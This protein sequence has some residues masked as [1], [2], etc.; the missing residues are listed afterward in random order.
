MHRRDFLHPARLLR[1]AGTI[2]GALDEARTLVKA[3]PQTSDDAVLLRFARRAMATIFEVI[4]P[5]GTPHAQHI[6]DD[7]LDLID[8]LEAQLTVYRAESEV[9]QLNQNAAKRAIAVEAELFRLLEL[10]QEL[11]TQTGGAFDIT[12]GALVKAWG[13]Y[14]RAGRVPSSEE[15]RSVR[16]KI[17]MR[18]LQFDTPSQTVRFLR[19]GLEINLASIGKGHALDRAVRLLRSKWKVPSA[20]VHGGHSS[21]F[22]VGSE[23]GSDEGWS[24]GLLDPFDASKRLAVLRL[25]DRGMGTS[26]ATYQHLEYQG[27]RL[28]HLLDPRTCWPAEEMLLAT[29]T[30]PT[31]AVADALAT[32]FFV[33]GVEQARAYC[34]DHPD[35]GAILLPKAE[36]PQIV[37]LGRAVAERTA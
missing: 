8:A 6:A 23:P 21:V 16:G 11:S 20:L 13:F 22:A 27:R 14:R 3:P 25:K 26:A 9:S 5:F 29:V 19:P 37:V 35:I 1:P 34:A 10:S 32:A 7:A 12:I 2:I 30:A 36:R 15:L 24:V 18:H 17:G 33:R 28:P 4:L 31:A